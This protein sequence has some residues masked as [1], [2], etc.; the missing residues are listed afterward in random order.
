M[1]ILESDHFFGNEFI[2]SVVRDFI[3]NRPDSVDLDKLR[4]DLIS[5][6][7]EFRKI[8]PNP[9][10]TRFLGGDCAIACKELRY[11]AIWAAHSVA[12]SANFDGKDYRDV[13]AGH[14]TIPYSNLLS[15]SYFGLGEFIPYNDI[16]HRF[17]STRIAF[18]FK[19]LVRAWEELSLEYVKPDLT[20]IDGS[21]STT[22]DHLKC[23]DR[24]YPET[25]EASEA[26][27]KLLGIGNI[28][29]MV[30]DSHSTDISR[31]LGY[32][33]TNMA[34]FDMA[35]DESE[36]V[37][38]ENDGIWVCYVKLPSKP[39]PF[40][41]EGWSS[42]FTV[43][44]EFNFKG[45]QESLNNLSGIWLR[46][47]DILHPQLYPLRMADHLTRKVKVGGILGQVVTSN[48]LALKFRDL[49]EG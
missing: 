25:K 46:E 37:V 30:E 29:G 27:T 20:L 49:R 26:M 7:F 47:D 24:G 17:D 11:H 14:G 9:V 28:V 5:K 45:F 48:K 4:R 36:Y 16:D 10:P 38:V 42:P 43:R 2:D 19:S 21:I 41:H 22:F 1:K 40:L 13:I 31:E 32:N 18:E 6:G 33:F 12:I 23:R 8:S 44:W 39:M 15:S 35:L 3:C 34:L